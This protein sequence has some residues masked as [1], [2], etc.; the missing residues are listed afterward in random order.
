MKYLIPL[1]CCAFNLLPGQDYNIELL[2]NVRFNDECANIWGY[3]NDGKEYAIIGRVS[4][5]SIFEVTDGKNP[6]L[7]LHIPGAR[8]QW[9]EI[10]SWKNYIYAVADQGK[11][12]LLIIN[13]SNAAELITYSFFR[14]QVT[15]NDKTLNIMKTDSLNRAHELFIDEKGF[16]YLTGSN[17][18]FG[19]TIFDLNK[20]PESPEF[21]GIFNSNYSHDAFARGD[22]LWSADILAG[23]FTVW[24]L[25]N[26]KNP[27]KLAFQQTGFAFTHNIWLSDDGRYA[28]TTDERA[29][30][31]VESY[32]VSDLNNITLLDKYRS[33][34]TQIRGT[35]PHNTYYH[36]G[37]LVTSYYTDGFT[38]V[39]ASNPAH[40]VEVG[41]FDTYPGGNEDFHGCWG[42]YPFLPSGN[43]IA[44]DIEFGLYVV[45]PTYKKAAY[46]KGVIKDSL[47][48]LVLGNAKIKIDLIPFNEVF[49]AP[50][51]T[52]K[53]G[54]PYTGEVTV[55][56]IKDGYRA[57]K[58]TIDLKQG[59]VSNTDILL[60]PLN[61]GEMTI[62]V[63]DAVTKQGIPNAQ[64]LFERPEARFIVNTNAGGS[65][66]NLINEGQWALYIGA[67]GYKFENRAVTVSTGSQLIIVE[68]SKR[69]ED[70]FVFDYGWTASSTANRG[71]WARVK[72]RGAFIR[73]KAMNP[74]HDLPDDAG[75]LCMVTGNGST[76]ATGDDVDAGFTKLITPVMDLT[77]YTQPI[78]SFYAWTVRTNLFDTIPSQGSHRVYLASGNDTLLLE[79][80]PP[81]NPAWTKYT[82]SLDPT[83][84]KNKSSVHLI[85]E[86]FEPPNIDT[87]N[88]V[89]FAVDGFLL[90]DGPLTANKEESTVA[91][92]YKIFPSPFT[93]QITIRGNPESFDRQI[94]F[95]NLNGRKVRSDN[96]KR[97]QSEVQLRP[98]I[99]SGIYFIQVVSTNRVETT[100]K[101][102]KL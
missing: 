46:L 91:S 20:N 94:D 49:S 25:N 43:I 41:A 102:I 88:I 21:V 97:L 75:E 47:S 101:I 74:N 16:C 62:L 32:D 80:L 99:S 55:E 63:V 76:A 5:T 33:R 83:K 26:K 36:N 14:P 11:D 84:I 93:D 35:I 98:E 64:I 96:W 27:I 38:I 23:E 39:D 6:S 34:T 82:I 69:Y 44:S 17:L 22:T 81:H 10:K 60:A 7:L 15:I 67:W 37:Y 31:F 57:K 71:I 59:E 79:T 78:L 42:V 85:F 73:E 61:K 30:A 13:M 92:K 45:K 8:S 3:A 51:G 56:I 77:A 65:S 24:D 12:G 53:T 1:L 87:R 2:S 90:T 68:L 70:Y 9:R 40:L 95:I 89:E 48:G 100:I 72:P 50:N 66:L 4:G 52:Y 28:F 58:I 29:N 54:A 18:H 19:V 86:A